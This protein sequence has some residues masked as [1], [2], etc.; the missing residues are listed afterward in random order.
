MD[1]KGK[2]M[3]N[4]TNNMNER[5]VKRYQYQLSELSF[6]QIKPIKMGKLPIWR[7]LKPIQGWDEGRVPGS[8]SQSENLAISIL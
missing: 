8:V 2:M 4:F 1:D 3:N 7:L 6:C 5:C